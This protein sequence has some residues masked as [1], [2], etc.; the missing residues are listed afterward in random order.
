MPVNSFI[1]TRLRYG[2]M[3]YVSVFDDTLLTIDKILEAN[4]QDILVTSGQIIN[5][6]ITIKNCSIYGPCVIT[7]Y[8]TPTTMKIVDSENVYY[9]IE[10]IDCIPPNFRK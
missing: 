8:I 6:V 3:D 9:K 7:S 1:Y 5:D 4:N 2:T 10:F